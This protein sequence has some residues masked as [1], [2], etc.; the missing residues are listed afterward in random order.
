LLESFRLGLIN[1]F[2][3]ISHTMTL[4]VGRLSGA[5][6]SLDARP[7]ESEGTSPPS[8]WKVNT[9]LRKRDA[10][11]DP[12]SDPRGEVSWLTLCLEAI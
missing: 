12:C 5:T 2:R 9:S 7:V 10:A 4:E 8:H 3:A 11:R 1:I 6:H